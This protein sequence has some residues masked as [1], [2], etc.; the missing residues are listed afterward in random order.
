[1]RF[2]EAVYVL[3]AFQKK[4]KHGKATPQRNVATIERR[5]AEAQAA[6]EARERG[7]RP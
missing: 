2:S 3:C 4:S 5:L 7:A 6:H 1:V